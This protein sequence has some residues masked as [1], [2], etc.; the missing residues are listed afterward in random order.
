L[1]SSCTGISPV[2]LF[3]FFTFGR[4]GSDSF[5]VGRFFLSRLYFP[6]PWRRGSEVESPPAKLWLT[7]LRIP[8]IGGDS[9]FFL[10]QSSLLDYPRG[11]LSLGCAFGQPLIFCFLLFSFPPLFSPSHRWQRS[12]THPFFFAPEPALVVAFPH[13]GCPPFLAQAPFIFEFFCNPLSLSLYVQA[14]FVVVVLERV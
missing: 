13:D 6:P 11:S 7:R 5:F 8:L 12:L 3:I 9:C 4:A 2:F 1:L 14:P 10:F